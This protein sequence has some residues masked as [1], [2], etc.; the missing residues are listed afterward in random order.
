MNSMT[1]RLFRKFRQWFSDDLQGQPGKLFNHFTSFEMI[2]P[3]V[4]LCFTHGF[5]LKSF[6][7]HCGSFSCSFSQKKQNF[8]HTCSLRSAISIFK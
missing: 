5:I 1:H 7:E 3:H 6:L 2:K 4:H 8:T